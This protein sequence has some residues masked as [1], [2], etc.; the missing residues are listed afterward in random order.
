MRKSYTFLTE[1]L[2]IRSRLA[3]V[4]GEKDFEVRCVREFRR[5]WEVLA[6]AWAVAPP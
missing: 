1:V 4:G 3:V 6:C 5:L 2:G